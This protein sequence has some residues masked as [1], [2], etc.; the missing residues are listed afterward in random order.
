[1]FPLAKLHPQFMQ[2]IFSP[3]CDEMQRPYQWISV[4]GYHQPHVT[5]PAQWST[6][7]SASSTWPVSASVLACSGDSSNDLSWRINSTGTSSSVGCW[8]SVLF[9]S[10]ARI[11]VICCGVGDI[12][13]YI[14]HMNSFKTEICRVLSP[15]LTEDSSVRDNMEADPR[16]PHIFSTCNRRQT[17]LVKN[18]F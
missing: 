2:T 5:S 11:S 4:I 3:F 16:I 8:N 17:D 1:M 12:W 6:S 7:L 15:P 14:C 18:E 13:T 9:P 10:D